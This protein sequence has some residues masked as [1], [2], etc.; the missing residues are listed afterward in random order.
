MRNTADEVIPSGSAYSVALLVKLVTEAAYGYILRL[1]G[2]SAE[3]SPAF[4]YSNSGGSYGKLWVAD[5]S[6]SV[7]TGFDPSFN[8]VGTWVAIFYT[9]STGTIS[10]ATNTF[11]I[12]G[13]AITPITG[14]G[15]VVDRATVLNHFQGTEGGGAYSPKVKYAEIIV[16]SAVMSDT[17]K[18]NLRNYWAHK[19]TLTLE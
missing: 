17:E 4:L 14:G 7:R 5:G 11:D 8:T 3:R 9:N 12:N 16:S 18:T 19:R 15:E 2:P 1:M 13:A 6:G 10:G